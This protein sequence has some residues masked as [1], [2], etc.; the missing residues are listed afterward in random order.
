MEFDSEGSAIAVK[1]GNEGLLNAVNEVI[2]AALEDG[3]MSQYIEEAQL[4]ASDD[5]DKVIEGMIDENG[6]LVG[7]A[8]TE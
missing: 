5:P 7:E 4:L 6:E 3:S 8:E 1:K 2:A